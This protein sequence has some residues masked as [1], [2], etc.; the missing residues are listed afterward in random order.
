VTRLNDIFKITITAIAVI[1]F[2]ACTDNLQEIEKMNTVS[3]EP[4][5]E[6]ENL[7]LK[8]TDSG[9]LKVTLSGKL[10]LDYS[11]DEFP[12]TEF[13]EGLKVEVYD[14]NTNPPEKTVITSDYGV[15]Y[16]E[17]NLVDLVGNVV[18]VTTDGST[19]LG[20]QL[21]WD[22][23]AQWLFTD[24]P[25]K[26]FINKSQ[27]SGDIIDSNEKLTKALVRNASDAY[28]IKPTNE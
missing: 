14:N 15:I 1:C 2:L 3:N 9:L 28:Y 22:Q 12:Y 25:Y 11:N 16:N 13:P 4:T 24:K 19:F 7:L 23:S 5:S 26:G 17:T 21:Y 27:V 6:V 10:M 20:D 18:I 8:H